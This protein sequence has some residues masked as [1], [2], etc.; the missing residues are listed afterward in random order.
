M[1][2]MTLVTHQT[3]PEGKIVKR[4]LIE[5]GCNIADE[6]YVDHLNAKDPFTGRQVP[7]AG[8]DPL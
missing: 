1:F 7:E 2:G 3:G 4:V 5:A 8:R 6:F